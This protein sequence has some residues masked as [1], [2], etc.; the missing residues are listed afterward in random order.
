VRQRANTRDQ[1]FT[2]P[3][4]IRYLSAWMTLEP[5]DVIATGTPARLPPPAG[6]DVFLRSGDTIRIA[7]ERI[8]ELINPV[9]AEGAD[10]R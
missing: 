7:I 8:G 3:F 1:I 2:I 6:G 9:R 10:P 4:L 5:G